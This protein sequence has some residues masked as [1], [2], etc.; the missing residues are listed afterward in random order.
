[1]SATHALANGLLAAPHVD[2]CP[3]KPYGLGSFGCD[4]WWLVLGKALVIFVFLLLTVLMSVWAERR[5]IGRMQLRPGPNR[6]GP[7]GLLQ[8]LL[9][10]VKGALKEDIV[11]RGV[12]KIVF[13]I[14]PVLAAAPAM[15][16]FAIIPFG[17]VVSI[18]G[19]K[20]A[21]QLT[22]LPVAVLLVLAMSSVGVYGFVL[23]G[24]A[25]MSPYSLLGGMRSSA[26]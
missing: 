22:D 9:D 1:M 25:S 19:H 4:P 7:F 16:S 12:D 10:G 20:T 13:F 26:Q 2:K 8:S 21:L 6:A 5:I 17:G 11:P 18:A 15:V 23:A 24:W 14:A 3:T